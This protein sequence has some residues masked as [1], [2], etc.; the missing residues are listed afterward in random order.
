MF[1]NSIVPP[2]SIWNPQPTIRNKFGCWILEF[3]LRNLYDTL[4]LHCPG[5]CNQQS[6]IEGGGDRN[7]TDE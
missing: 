3:E 4:H 1:F 5:G 6:E 7:R 2:V